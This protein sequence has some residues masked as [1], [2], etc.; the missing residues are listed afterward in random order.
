MN[1]SETILVVEDDSSTR[2]ILTT[3][4]EEEGF[5]VKPFPTAEEALNQIAGQEPVDI[6]ISDLKL[7]DGSG[8]KI[9]WAMKKLKPAAAFILITGYASVET[10]IEAVNEGAFA[11]HVKP[12]DIDALRSSVRNAIRQKRLLAENRSLL[13]RV[14]RYNEELEKK[15]TELEQAS[16]AKSQI[17]A[18][19]SHELKTPLTSIVCYTDRI[20][21][22]QDSVGPLNERQRRYLEIVRE[23]SNRLKGMIDDLLDVSRIEADHLDLSIGELEI[24]QEFEDAI[25]SL[26]TQISQKGI[27][28]ALEISSDLPRVRADKLRFCQVAINL[29]SN[30]CKYS[31]PRL[32]HHHHR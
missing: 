15:N 13:D 21:L 3:L 19:V 2:I 22:Q 29:L 9:L 14:R 30:A 28:M 25:R 16:L 26:Q 31:P 7:P 18:T 23:N 4:L 12:L 27:R 6:V 8:L 32:H 5:Q 1:N 24:G 20:L 10:A 17:L 11:Y